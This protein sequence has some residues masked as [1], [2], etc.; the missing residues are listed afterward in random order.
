MNLSE[1]AEFCTKTAAEAGAAIME[2]Y[3]KNDFT[4]E[5]KS[6][7]SPITLADKTSNNIIITALHEK[8]PTCAIL[9]EESWDESCQDRLLNDYCFIVDP[10]DGTK[11]FI[12]RNGQ[13]TVNIALSYKGKAVVGVIYVP[14]TEEIFFA[15]EGNGA[16]YM[17]KPNTLPV[18]INVTDKLTDLIVVGSRSHST[19]QEKQL[20]KRN[21]HLISETI[22]VGS[23]LK[24]CMVAR[25][26]ADVYYRFG[27]TWEW[28][29]AA[30]QCILE[31]SGGIFR[32]L[33]GSEMRYN[34][35]NIR[36]EKGFFAVNR[37]ENIWNC[38]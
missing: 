17:S 14:V 30:Q 16:Y 22:S 36:N 6:D 24:G 10:L 32:Q 15:S 13:F 33:D 9:A 37:P 4:V 7:N 26:I 35:K 25:G 28:D 20:L 5:H 11:E 29:T 18:K 8:Y 38:E 12:S 23:S 27:L 19:E 3:E 1:V 34:R 21:S 2:I 31:Q